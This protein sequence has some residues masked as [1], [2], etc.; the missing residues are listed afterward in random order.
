MESRIDKPK[1]YT[2]RNSLLIN[3]LQRMRDE[4]TNRITSAT[5]NERLRVELSDHNID[6]VRTIIGTSILNIIKPRPI[7]MTVH[8]YTDSRK[9]LKKKK[10]K[11]L[12]FQLPKIWLQG[13]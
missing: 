3:N 12:M 4:N 5:K 2:R 7:A 6:P 1:Y 11:E 10:V 8:R 13:E 9:I